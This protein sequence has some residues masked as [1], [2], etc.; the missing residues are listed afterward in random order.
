[1][2]NLPLE[3]NVEL[4]RKYQDRSE[5]PLIFIVELTNAIARLTDQQQE[6]LAEMLGVE[7]RISVIRFKYSFSY[8][9]AY[10]WRIGQ[11]RKKLMAEYQNVRWE[12]FQQSEVKKNSND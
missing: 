5:Y 1:M 2:D 8:L 10:T 7:S 9:G 11:I 4:L 6:Q 3:I 12:V